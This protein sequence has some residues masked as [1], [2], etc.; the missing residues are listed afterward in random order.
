MILFVDRYIIHKDPIKDV[1]AFSKVKEA[2][3][4]PLKT[5][6]FLD[7]IQTTQTHVFRDHISKNP[8][9]HNALGGFKDQTQRP[10]IP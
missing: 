5:W 2:K 4:R 6:F 7:K 9:R 1:L 10:K 8:N 3:D